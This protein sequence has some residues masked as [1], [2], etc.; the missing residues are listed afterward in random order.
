MTRKFVFLLLLFSYLN[1]E[2]FVGK[3]VGVQDGDTITVLRSGR[4][5]K[6]RLEGIDSP[7]DGQSFSNKAKKFTSG[8]VFGKTVT[9]RTKENDRYGRIVGRVFVGDL[10]IS[11]EIV[12]NGYAW[13]FKK[14]S[15]E[16]MLANAQQYAKTNSLGLWSEYAPISPGEYRNRKKRS[17]YEK[18]LNS[19]TFG[20]ARYWLNTKTNVRHNSSCR[21]FKKTKY[22]RM[23]T[24]DEGK[25]CGICGG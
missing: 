1:A 20:V 22:G 15:K 23:C 5:V 9:V 12:R 11:R 18:S 6:V 25:A 17:A 2:S 8:L 3:C 10:D 21:Y 24:K 4:A 14:Y 7:E 19:D 13:H 16:K